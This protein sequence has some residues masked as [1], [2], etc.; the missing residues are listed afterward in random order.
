MYRS[1]GA[2]TNEY[3]RRMQ[4]AIADARLLGLSEDYL[5]YTLGPLIFR[6][7]TDA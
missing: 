4:Q 7:E 3:S 5:T 1:P 6:K 2:I